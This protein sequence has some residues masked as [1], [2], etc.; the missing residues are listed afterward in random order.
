M[1]LIKSTDQAKIQ[2]LSPKD[3]LT[4]QTWQWTENF[5]MKQKIHDKYHS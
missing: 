3:P 1:K 5:T 2:S 4:E